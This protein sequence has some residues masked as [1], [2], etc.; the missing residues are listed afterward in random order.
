MAKEKKNC[1]PK[2]GYKKALWFSDTFNVDLLTV[3]FRTRTRGEHIGFT[4][5]DDASKPSLEKMASNDNVATILHLLDRFGVS[6]IF[7]HELSMIN[8]SLPRSHLVKK[9][10]ERLNNSVQVL[11]LPRP[12]TGCYRSFAKCLTEVLETQVQLK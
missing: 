10:R 11:R 3:S 7:Y 4:Y 9:E 12:Y 1:S 5:S 8:P 2:G 6:D